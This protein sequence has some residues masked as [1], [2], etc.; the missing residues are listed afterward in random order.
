MP[1]PP[2]PRAEPAQTPQRKFTLHQQVPRPA[3][4]AQRWAEALRER[5]ATW[6]AQHAN[7]PQEAPRA[8]DLHETMV[9]H[10]ATL[11]TA[12]HAPLSD[13]NRVQ[14]L[15]D[16][17]A[18][19]RAMFEA[20]DAARDHINIESYTIEAEGPGQELA[21]RLINKRRQGVKVN[22]LFDHFGSWST[23]SRFFDALREAGVQM[24]CYN[25]L[26]R[27]WKAALDRTMHLRDHRKLLIVD[28][29]VAFTGGVNIS[30]VYSHP[31]SKRDRWLARRMP[32]RDTHVRIEGPVVAHLQQLF[33]DHWLAQTGQR[34]YL[35]HFFP[36]LPFAGEHRA[37]VAACEGGGRR[38]PF[39]VALLRAID[40]AQQ[41]ICITA[42]YFVPPRRLLRALVRAAARGVAVKLVLPSISDSWAALH[43]GRSHYS[44][45]L[46][47]GVRIYER[48]GALLHAKT[49]VIDG[50][51]AT[52]GSSNLD[53]RSM[54]HNAEAN[55]VVL[56]RRFACELET[57][58]AD[59]LCH[60][61]EVTLANWRQRGRGQ[62][63]LEAVARRFEFFL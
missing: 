2:L 63:V 19:Y 43:A 55:L 42:A 21:R 34:P 33:L 1:T 9:R 18:T 47:A 24:C 58:F 53:W 40:L 16:G 37:G 27:G 44:R 20:I 50:L 57:V 28:G 48:Q 62:R 5:V 13:G 29:K 12:L 30:S 61:T 36:R 32:W 26:V 51:W 46:K 17:P 6:R 45:L 60:S 11:E 39:Y 54:L 52:V 38:N 56:D 35:S 7:P 10:A 23:H 25:P 49:A 14:V 41:S 3:P 15:V 31:S 22:L 59:D 4:P 8:F